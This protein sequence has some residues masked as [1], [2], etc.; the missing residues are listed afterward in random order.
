MQAE[1]AALMEAEEAAGKKPP[2]LKE[3]K[4]H[5]RPPEEEQFLPPMDDFT[6]VEIDEKY[7]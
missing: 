6:E 2:E 4:V 1:M 5:I 3:E 7:G